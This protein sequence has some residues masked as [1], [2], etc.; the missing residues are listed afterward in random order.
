MIRSAFGHA[1]AAHAAL[2]L[3]VLRERDRQATTDLYYDSADPYQNDEYNRLGL[4]AWERSAV[5]RWFPERGRILVAGAGG[6][7]EVYG[8]TRL[9]FTAEGFEPNQRLS[10]HASRWLE[11]EGVAARVHA[12]GAS[13]VP[14]AIQGHYD[15]VLIGWG[16]YNHITPRARR[17][18]FLAE[19]RGLLKP[20][21]AVI[22]SFHARP[23]EARHFRRV[24]RLA[25]LVRR[26]WPGA[27]PVEEG[28]WV[29][30]AFEHYFTRYE[31]E[32]EL[33]AAGFR[34]VH[35][36][37]VDYAHAVGVLE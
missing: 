31:V 30:L 4:Q 36:S 9:G 33:A 11:R 24:S 25:N 5:E 7:R 37:T 16:A 32:A 27:A 18:E 2:W 22:L 14:V 3:A 12:A 35:H 28:D 21:S 29:W 17:V 34:M 13:G 26:L 23:E 15:G 1:H 8:L 10:E 19:L 20:G 6:G